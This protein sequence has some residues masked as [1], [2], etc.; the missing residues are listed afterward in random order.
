MIKFINI[1]EMS[2]SET[3]PE[4]I[5]NSANITFRGNRRKDAN[6]AQANFTPLIS[7]TQ[8]P[9]ESLLNFFLHILEIQYIHGNE[10]TKETEQGTEK[11]TKDGENIGSDAI[12]GAESDNTQIKE[13]TEKPKEDEENVDKKK[14]ENTEDNRRT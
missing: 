7:L 2:L 12:E 9:H 4:F 10:D 3:Q 11:P 8:S 1:R 6:I 5:R 14:R 13:D